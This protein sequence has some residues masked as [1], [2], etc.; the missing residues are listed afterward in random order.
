MLR[1]EQEYKIAVER[2]KEQLALIAQQEKILKTKE[3]SAA[4]IDTCLQPLRA[5]HSNLSDEIL[6]YEKTLRGEFEEIN[7]FENIGKF[8]IKSRIFKQIN[9]R[10]LAKRLDVSES[11]ISRD[12]KNEYHGITCERVNKVLCALGITLRSSIYDSYQDV[13][14]SDY[15]VVSENSDNRSIGPNLINIENSNTPDNVI[16]IDKNRKVAC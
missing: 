5:F 13:R 7:N 1:T 9:Q 2:Y 4:E 8:L 6:E 12:E 11:Q 15:T 3:L 16:P 10:D 14:T